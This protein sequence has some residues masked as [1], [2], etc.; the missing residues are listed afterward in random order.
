MTTVTIEQHT[1]PKDAPFSFPILDSDQHMVEPVTLWQ[2]RVDKKF[3]DRAPAPREN[4]KGQTGNFLVFEDEALRVGQHNAD[5][6]KDTMSRKGG[7][8]PAARLADMQI[9]GVAAAVLFPTL[10]TICFGGTSDAALQQAV[11]AA[12]N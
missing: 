9:D 11:F 10:A 1:P 2:E 7:W 12:Y 3:R 8:D 4:F 6:E 5:P